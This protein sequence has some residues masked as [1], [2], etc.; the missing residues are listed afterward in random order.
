MALSYSSN[1]LLLFSLF[2]FISI[3]GF[4]LKA[5]IAYS[6]TANPSATCN[7]NLRTILPPPYSDLSSLSCSHIWQQKFSFS[8]YQDG[9]NVTTIVLSGKNNHQW[10]GIGFSRNGSM[11]GSSAMVAWVEPNGVSG[12]RQYHLEGKNMSK[13]IPDKGDLKFTTARP[14]VVAHGDLL[15][16][17]FQ[18]QFA[19]SLAFQPILLAIGSANPYKNGSLPKHINSTTTFIEFSSGFSSFCRVILERLG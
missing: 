13:V 6:N 16:I 7:T 11:V 9:Q 4:N 2:C 18:L 5:V 14:V 15:Y 12:I 1:K 10:I 3:V 19:A 17:A 8:F